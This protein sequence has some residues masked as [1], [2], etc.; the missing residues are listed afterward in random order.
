MPLTNKE[1]SYITRK[2]K[3]KKKMLYMQKSTQY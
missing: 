3:K 2:K 1:K